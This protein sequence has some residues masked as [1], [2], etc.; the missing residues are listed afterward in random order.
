MVGQAQGVCHCS[1]AQRLPGRRR[2]GA[3]A[4]RCRARARS[5]CCARGRAR[6]QPRPRPRH[7]R[8][9]T[10]RRRVVALL[11]RAACALPD[12]PPEHSPPGWFWLSAWYGSEL[13]SSARP[14]QTII[15]AHNTGWHGMG[16][17]HSPLYTERHMHQ[18]T[19]ASRSP[20]TPLMPCAGRP[21]TAPPRRRPA[22]L[23]RPPRRPQSTCRAR[24]AARVSRP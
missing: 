6:P 2:A 14:C 19:G 16:K 5:A 15:H 12:P 9:Q 8:T 10:C 17:P 7:P 1:R 4:A 20:R 22:A 21:R 23:R 11:F 13:V 24:R 3:P 18:A